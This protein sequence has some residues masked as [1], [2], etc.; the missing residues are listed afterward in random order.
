MPVV[1]PRRMNSRASDNLGVTK[2]GFLNMRGNSLNKVVI[3]PTEEIIFVSIAASMLGKLIPHF[4]YNNF[5]LH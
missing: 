4:F 1:T 3:V 5:C 2:C